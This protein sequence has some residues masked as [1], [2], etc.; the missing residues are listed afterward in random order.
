MVVVQ[1][2]WKYHFITSSNFN[3]EEYFEERSVICIF[4]FK[5]GKKFYY[6]RGFI[7]HSLKKISKISKIF[8]NLICVIN[9]SEE[10]PLGFD[11][12]NE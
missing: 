2:I 10:Q 11:K 5:N 9:I 12:P 8:G 6:A 1:T 7:G 4:N 3:W